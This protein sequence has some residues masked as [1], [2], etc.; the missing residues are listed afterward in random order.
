V[1][2]NSLNPLY[3][4]SAAARWK[5]FVRVS[6]FPCVVCYEYD[7]LFLETINTTEVILEV[8]C[9]FS[10]IDFDLVSPYVTSVLPVVAKVKA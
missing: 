1:P 3:P 7:L 10:R 8:I 5:N 6:P 4:R 9:C 2:D